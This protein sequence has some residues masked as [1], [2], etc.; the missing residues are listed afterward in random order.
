MTNAVDGPAPRILIVEDDP[1]N[2]RLA[3]LAFR[4]SRA[5]VSVHG[6]A[7]GVLERVAELRPALVLL[8]VMMPGLEG[9][10]LVELLRADA[11]LAGTRVVLWSAL[12]PELLEQKGR[13]CGADATFEKVAG[14]SALL[15][16]IS[17]WLLQWDGIVLV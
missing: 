10:S 14:P 5:E 1:A 6:R 2:A 3:E 7:F 16:Q 9:P 12:D 8:D 15:R 17:T 4:N 13:E 11:E